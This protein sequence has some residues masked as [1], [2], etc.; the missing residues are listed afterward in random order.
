MNTD[1]SFVSTSGYWVHQHYLREPIRQVDEHT[2]C[3]TRYAF[4]SSSKDEHSPKDESMTVRTSTLYRTTSGHSWV[5][6]APY[7][8][9]NKTLQQGRKLYKQLLNYGYSKDTAELLPCAG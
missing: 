3:Q 4:T 5:E 8:N 6:H 2:Q 7:W 1:K 9:V